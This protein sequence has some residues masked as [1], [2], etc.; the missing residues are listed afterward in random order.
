MTLSRRV[1][2]FL[3][4]CTVAL[5]AST[6]LSLPALKVPILPKADIRPAIW[7]G[8]GDLGAAEMA[9]EYWSKGKLTFFL[10]SLRIGYACRAA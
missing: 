8:S 9:D 5:M 2:Q 4:L 6:G 10:N 3:P 1:R 7:R